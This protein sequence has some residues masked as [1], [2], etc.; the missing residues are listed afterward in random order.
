MPNLSRTFVRLATVVAFAGGLALTGAAKAETPEMPRYAMDQTSTHMKHQSGEKALH[1]RKKMEEHI[2]DR[3]KTLH[4][5]LDITEAQEAKW[6]EVAK[7]MRDNEA[8]ISELI[9]QRYENR[10][11]MTAIDD[12]Q[13]YEAISEAHTDGLKKMIPPFQSLYNDMTDEQKKEADEAFGRFEGHRGGK[14][15][16]KKG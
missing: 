15:G 16:H 1:D 12:L 13:S 3:I 9:K 11:T 10:K 6:N 7:T 8:A 5:K 4:D 14:A 2:E